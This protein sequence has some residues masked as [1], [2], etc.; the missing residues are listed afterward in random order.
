MRLDDLRPHIYRTRDSGKTWTEIVSGIP[1]NE[2]VNS[3]RED[4]KRQ[5]L[6]FAGTERAVYVSFDDGDHWQSLRLNMPAT[7]V[8]DLTIKEN[9]LAVGTHGRGF[10]ILD[11]ITLLRQLDDKIVASNAFLF[12]PELAYRLRWDTN[13]DTPLPPD[14][15]A[16]QNPPDGAIFNYYLKSTAGGPVTL[17]ILDSAGAVVRRYSS[18]D[19]VPAPDP[20]LP[21]PAY[22]LRPPQMLSSAAGVHRFVWDMHYPPVPG[23]KPEYPIA[24]VPWNTAPAPTSP[25]I[26]PGKYSVVLTVDA[27]R[28]TQPLTIEMDPRVKTS[29]ADLQKQFELSKQIY[30]DLLAL[31]PVTEK[32]AAALTKL[33]SMREK[34]IAAEATRIDAAI[35]QLQSLEGTGG[36]RR[37][38]AQADTLS[39]VHGSLMEMLSVLQDVDAAPTTQAS[40]AVPKLSQ[41]TTSMVQR[42]QEFESK[43]LAPLQVQP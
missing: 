41:S 14:E 18:A 39:G 25:W 16:G 36:R 26:M 29:T 19:P 20:E 34:A 24:A 12:A 42:W 3:V 4:P 21:I 13:T 37:R 27:Q 5:G 28:Y 15:P 35:Q 43:Q 7:S 11:D 33:K 1:Q 10:W 40:Q 32:S 17:E 8:R 38:G 22:W 23:M 6:L 2:N 9:D 31:Q 30:D